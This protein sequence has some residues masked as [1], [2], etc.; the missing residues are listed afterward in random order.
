[1]G[2]GASWLIFLQSTLG[3]QESISELGKK[4]KLAAIKNRS[5][6]ETV[7]R[8]LGLTQAVSNII[9]NYLVILILPIPKPI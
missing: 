4:H 5:C 9:S 7:F 2:L 3:T 6:E 8:V 1:M